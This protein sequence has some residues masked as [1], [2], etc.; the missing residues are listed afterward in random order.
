MK[1]KKGG[2]E[3][4]K[5][6]LR[7]TGRSVSSLSPRELEDRNQRALV[8]RPSRGESG[9]GKKF[10][11]TMRQRPPGFPDRTLAE[12]KRFTLASSRGRSDPSRY[13]QAPQNLGASGECP[14]LQATPPA[15]IGW[16]WLIVM[17]MLSVWRLLKV[18]VCCR[19]VVA[20]AA[21]ALSG[22]EA[23]TLRSP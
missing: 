21:G 2:G 11:P 9:G 19:S 16:G 18:C 23:G 14:E 3:K 7:C 13:Q 17:G 12:S 20:F 4:V 5:R 15:L 1:R 10:H 6:G 22:A 8:P